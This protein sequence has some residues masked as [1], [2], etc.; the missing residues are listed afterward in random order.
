MKKQKRL[1]ALLVLLSMLIALFAGQ[2]GA[3]AADS[4]EQT[5][6]EEQAGQAEQAVLQ[7]VLAGAEVPP[8]SYESLD[9]SS[10]PEAV[11]MEAAQERMHVERLYEEEGD[12][13]NNVI[14]RNADGSKTLYVFPYPVKYV[15]ENGEIRDISL[16]IRNDGAKAGAYRSAA[17][18]AQTVLPG[19]LSEGISLSSPDVELTLIPVC[20]KPTVVSA[21][22]FASPT[23]LTAFPAATKISE[24]T[25]SYVYDEKTT[26]EYSLTYTGF[27]EDIVVREYTG[28]TEYEFLLHTNGLV[29]KEIDGSY[30]LCDAAG[31]IKASVGDIVIFTADERNNAMGSLSFETIQETQTYR[32][33]IHVDA[34]Y[35]RDERTAYP[36]RIDP[37]IEISYDKSGSGAVE[38]VTINSKSGSLGS[39]G[40]LMVG[41]RSENG[42]SRI[43]MR[44]PTLSLSGIPSA[45]CITSAFV[46][47]RDL[48]CESEA[49]TVSC[50]PFTGSAW[51]ESTASWLN[52]SPNS[53]GAALSSHSISYANGKKQASAHRYSFDITAAVQGWKNGNYSQNKGLLFKAAGSVESGGTYIHKTIASYNRA[54]YRPSL[55]VN[56]YANSAQLVPDGTYYLN[57]KYSGDY[58]K[59]ESAKVSVVSGM[60][61]SLGPPLYWLIRKVDGGYVIRSANDTSKYLAV[62]S[63][64]NSAG[65]ELVTITNGAIPARCKWTITNAAGI[66]SLIKNVYNSSY[67]YTYGSS[68][69][70]PRSLGAS[71]S[72]Q[73]ISKGWRLVKTSAY[74]HTSSFTYC[75]MSAGTTIAA[76]SEAVGEKNLPTVKKQSSKEIWCAPSD[77]VYSG[78][79]STIISVDPLTGTITGKRAG[80]TTVTATHK[81]TGRVVKFNVTINKLLIYQT[82][83]TYY[84]DKDGNLPEDL[85]YGDMT[86]DEIRALDWINW[87]NFVAF[88]P[89]LHRTCWEDMCSVAFSTGGLQV[90]ILDMIDH[91]ML[92]SGTPYSNTK[93]TAAA[94]RHESTQTYI[95]LVQEQ[96]AR[97]MKLCNGDITDLTYVAER[98]DHNPLVASMKNKIDQPVF[99]NPSDKINGLTICVDSLWGN[100]I[101]VSS[102]TVSANSFTCTLHYTLYD[103][104]GLDRPDVEKYGCLPGFQSWYILQHYSEYCGRYLPFLTLMEFDVTFSG[105]LN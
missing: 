48:M 87:A 60:L 22:A 73:Y 9:E 96:I 69:N 50:H 84:Y 71:G 68:L 3:L 59:C 31:E 7:A 62:P 51:K 17:S 76:F 78:Y 55:T 29:P 75:E 38:D 23:A 28:Q 94:Y 97:L 61:T 58:L 5:A 35:L 95:S 82:E 15:S 4:T 56:Y 13:L 32:F 79:S 10:V 30:F 93:L 20:K 72:A 92:G 100:K 6:Q 70:T 104:F 91:F 26:L 43:L 21:K 105:T 65:V 19:R 52:V 41:L 64:V 40:S 81:V 86:K 24:K 83:N 74:G 103:H 34:D 18:A 47:L 44:F 99:N 49:L 16:N 42:I 39:S 67:L 101:E 27:K 77:F 14:F 25:V 85:Q 45:D 37:S 46:E 98:R 53:Y 36:I 80:A 102:F 54:A 33:V 66:G 8:E 57:N 2:P 88:T 11:G 63:D 90:V 89:E 1:T 12:A